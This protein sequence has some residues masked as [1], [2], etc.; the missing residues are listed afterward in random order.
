[1]S[2][3]LTPSGAVQ[4]DSDEADDLHASRLMTVQE[5]ARMMRVTPRT[6]QRWIAKG[7]LQAV[8][9]GGT[10]R[11]EHGHLMEIVTPKEVS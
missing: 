3:Y 1:M 8:K 2:T 5:V 4:T 6:V 9:V 7:Y 11:I 10:T